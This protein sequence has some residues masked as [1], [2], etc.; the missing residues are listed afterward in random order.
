MTL[1]STWIESNQKN[2]IKFKYKI[3]FRFNSIQFEFYWKK[4]GMQ[5]GVED[6]ESAKHIAICNHPKGNL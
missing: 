1:H 3:E 2:L 5:I 4:N 6:S